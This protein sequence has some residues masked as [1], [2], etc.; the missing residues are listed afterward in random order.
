M[1]TDRR[2]DRDA[3]STAT[4]ASPRER[5]APGIDPEILGDIDD[6]VEAIGQLDA[7]DC[8]RLLAFWRGIDP[9]IRATAIE[10]ARVAA[11]ANERL[12]LIGSVQDEILGFAQQRDTG[13]RPNVERWFAPMGTASIHQSSW[14]DAMPALADAT[15]ALALQDV[16]DDT[17]FDAL[18]GPWLNA[19]GST[20]YV[21]DDT[22]QPGGASSPD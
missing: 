21:E 6:L 18:F 5:L 19:M 13:D 2:S 16:L 3:R 15:T 11:E 10:D 17:D 14:L 22:G 12:A 8:D 1:K 20:D 7:S 4:G 9:D